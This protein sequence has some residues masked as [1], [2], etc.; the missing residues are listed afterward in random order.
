MDLEE[1]RKVRSRYLNVKTQEKPKK[2]IKWMDVVGWKEESH[3][4]SSNPHNKFEKTIP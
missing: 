3:R 1:E 2:A 4:Q